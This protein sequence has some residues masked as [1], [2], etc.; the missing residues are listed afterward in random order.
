MKTSKMMISALLCAAMLLSGCSSDNSDGPDTA[1]AAGTV[2]ETADATTA[3]P[4][5]EAT[6][7]TADTTT[8]PLTTT[9]DDTV[10]E[11]P[12]IDNDASLEQ[13]RQS[14]ADEQMMA[15][16][17]FG[18]VDYLNETAT[19]DLMPALSPSACEKYPFVN[20][21]TDGRIIGDSYGDLFCI[22]P[23][24][25]GSTVAINRMYIDEY[26]NFDYGEVIYR[27][28]VGEPVLLYCNNSAFEADTQ[29]NITDS[30]GNISTWYPST[31]D[32][33]GIAQIY[34]DDDSEL[35]CD[36]TSYNDLL[37]YKYDRMQDEGWYAPT[38]EQLLDTSWEGQDYLSDGSI[39]QYYLDIFENTVNV[40]WNDGI[41]A[42]GHTYYDAEWSFTVE[43]GI[44][45]LTIDFRE[46]AGECTYAI[47]LSD[48]ETMMYTAMDFTGAAIETWLEKTDRYLMRTYG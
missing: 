29:V 1:E 46:F 2:T 31:D 24:D 12:V 40:Q 44:A 14:M 37:R 16:I 4:V 39:A 23:R 41:D 18:C 3:P 33:N 25:E 20:D 47:L 35:I 26:G 15:V 5:S 42:D 28:E 36:L 32:H 8:E 22:I 6:T 13:L 17:Y 11:P 7:T 34:N 27:S 48:D 43:D 21:I 19:H 10:T 30:Q 45:L 38:A 9:G